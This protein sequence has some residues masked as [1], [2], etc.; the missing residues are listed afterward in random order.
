MTDWTDEIQW[1]ERGLVPAIAQEV[2]T[3]DILMLA[4]MNREALHQ[5]AQLGRA[6]YFSRSRGRLWAKG[7]ESGHVQTVHEIRL[8]CDR[9]VIVLKVTQEGHTPSIACHT[10]RHSCFF[11]T[12]KGG[13]WHDVDPIIKPAQA[14]YG[15]AHTPSQS[16]QPPSA[17]ASAQGF[18]D[19][20]LSSADVLE[21]IAETL[22]SRLPANGG[23]PTSSYAAKLLAAGS[24]AFLKKIGEEATEVA[25][26]AKD[27]QHGAGSASH[28][29]YE[30]ADLWFHTL[31]ALT[32]FGIS[33][34][35]VLDELDRRQGTSGLAEK[36][37]RAQQSA[38][39]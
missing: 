26:A 13:R 36:A 29:V 17:A 11:R 14:I 28:L 30:V 33:P 38:A 2:S 8:D 10:G 23:D 5:T 37:A 12:L 1:D 21:R 39:S 31:V 16:A 25:L 24:D 22:R 32:H 20:G 34:Q 18:L 4:W 15:Q 6:V 35:A 19:D 27:A 9:D 3:G 7:E